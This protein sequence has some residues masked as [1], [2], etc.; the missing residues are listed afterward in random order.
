M[1]NEKLENHTQWTSP[2]IQN[3]LLSILTDFVRQRIVHDVHES[4]I[5]AVI[6]DETSDISRIEQVSLCLSYIADGVKKETFIGFYK[7]KSTEG[8]VLYE[9]LKKAIEDLNLNK[10]MKE[11]SP[12][13]IYIFIA[14]GIF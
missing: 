12:L 10:R 5:F 11:C 1:L 13:A 6:L 8:E 2:N 4:G 9:L 3:E 14:M 7:T